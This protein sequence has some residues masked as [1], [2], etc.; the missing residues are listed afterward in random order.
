LENAVDFARQRVEL[1]ARWDDGELAVTITDDGPGFSPEVAGR[2][3]E[4]YVTSRHGGRPGPE[5]E[6]S[7]LGLGF[8]IAKTLLE[9][10]GATLSS[11]NRPPPQSGATVRVRWA[12]AD[13]DKPPGA[14][15]QEAGSWA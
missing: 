9:R 1:A 8:F 5:G 13:F 11:L 15:D 10:T 14:P 7:G 2:I 12:R 4:P 3:G 6:T